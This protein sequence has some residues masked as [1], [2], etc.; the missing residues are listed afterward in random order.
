MIEI[1]PVTTASDVDAA[2][3]LFRE[4]ASSGHEVHLCLD[5][6]AAEVAA[7]PGTYAPPDGALL[8]AWAD[9]LAV[10]TVAL[11]PLEGR[12]AELKRL[13]VRPVVRGQQVGERL[14]LAALAAARDASYRA[15]RLDTLPS[16]EAAQVIYER[17]GFRPIPP[18]GERPVAGARHFELT[19]APER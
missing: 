14:V 8:V 3:E 1:R 17:V 19:L 13:Y 12:V 4:Y 7:L 9:G 5:G 11:R 16:M 2:R 15:V 6:I 10:G 18:Y